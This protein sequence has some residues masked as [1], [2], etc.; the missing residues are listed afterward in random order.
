MSSS[1]PQ[2]SSRPQQQLPAT[3]AAHAAAGGG[4]TP[5]IQNTVRALRSKLM[6]GGKFGGRSGATT[7][8]ASGGVPTSVGSSS[9]LSPPTSVAR[10]GPPGPAGQQ[11]PVELLTP[12]SGM[13]RE[14]Q[15]AYREAFQ[16]AS[17]GGG[18][19]EGKEGNSNDDDEDSEEALLKNTFVTA[20]LTL[21]QHGA[22]KQQLADTLARTEERGAA[23]VRTLELERDMREE[24]LKSAATKKKLLLSLRDQ[25]RQ[26]TA[27]RDRLL[28]QKRANQHSSTV[29]LERTLRTIRVQREEL[30]AQVS[31]QTATHRAEQAAV[32]KLRGIIADLEAKAEHVERQGFRVAKRQPTVAEIDNRGELQRWLS[33]LRGESEDKRKAQAK[34]RRVREQLA[35]EANTRQIATVLR[36]DVTEEHTGA[37]G[38]GAELENLLSAHDVVTESKRVEKVHDLQ[39]R[40]LKLAWEIMAPELLAKHEERERERKQQEAE[41]ANAPEVLQVGGGGGGGEALSAPTSP[42]TSHINQLPESGSDAK[43]RSPKNKAHRLPRDEFGADAPSIFPPGGSGDLRQELLR[44][45]GESE[46]MSA[47]IDDGSGAA[48]AKNQQQQGGSP[49]GSASSPRPSQASASHPAT[50][51]A[52]PVATELSV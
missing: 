23:F 26:E 14:I 39:L 43:K 4:V 28:A 10:R 38:R 27:R 16:S 51:T 41:K 18:S 40:K 37:L 1:L 46:E 29:A 36:P 42:S 30:E 44:A 8:K 13:S 32:L 9:S 49:A 25:I 21:I 19:A 45:I 52:S 22:L 2:P 20:G 12:G 33:L 48:A 5:K 24:Q 31:A 35:A 50:G 6:N 7:T 47:L 34:E 15:D 3:A 11:Q 17:G